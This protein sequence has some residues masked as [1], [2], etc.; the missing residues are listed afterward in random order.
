M[1]L[2]YSQ[3]SF[4][5]RLFNYIRRFGAFSQV[6]YKSTFAAVINIILT[7]RWRIMKTLLNYMWC[8]I[9]IIL[10]IFKFEL[11]RCQAIMNR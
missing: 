9:E 8:G 11:Q 7:N 4:S 6:Y 3:N 2:S 5:A 1:G 10:D